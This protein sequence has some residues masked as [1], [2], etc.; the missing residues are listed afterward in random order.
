VRHLA[1]PFGQTAC[2]WPS[3]GSTAP[4]SWRLHSA[5]SWCRASNEILLRLSAER[6]G[7]ACASNEVRPAPAGV[8]GLAPVGLR[9]EPALCDATRPVKSLAAVE[10]CEPGEPD[11]PLAEPLG[12]LCCELGRCRCRRCLARKQAGSPQRGCKGRHR[13]RYRWLARPPSPGRWISGSVND[14][15]QRDCASAS[16]G[17]GQSI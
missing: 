12:L 7:I 13:N 8:R 17:G 1:R 5:Q 9:A 16:S 10:P 15:W 3:L 6:F 11:A 4:S 2:N 14:E